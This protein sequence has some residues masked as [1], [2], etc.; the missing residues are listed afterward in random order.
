[1]STSADAPRPATGDAPDDPVLV[2]P[3]GV[4]VLLG[5]AAA[6]VVIAGMKAS[7]DLVG[8][9]FLA[10][11]L[12]VTA[13]PLHQWLNRHLPWRLGTL[14]CLLIVYVLIVVL[15][16]ALVAAM[17]RF[18][19]LLTTYEGQFDDLVNDA[20]ARLDD[21][22]VSAEQIDDAASSL[23]LGGLQGVISSALAGLVGLVSDLAFIVAL[24][25]FMTLDGGEFPKRLTAAASV[26]PQL[27]AAFGTFATGTRT[28]LLVATVFGAI[29]AT[30]DT[31]A[32]ALLGIP[33]PLVW[34]LLA[35]LT[36]YIPNI[37]FVIG[38]IPPAILG[39]LEEGPGLMLAVI[40]VY[41]VLNM[42]IQSGIQPKVVGDAV[43]LS[44][45]L[46]FLSLVF[47]TWVI[48]P[49]G[50]IL[51]I[52]LSLLV[53]AVLVDADPRNSWLTPLVANR[54]GAPE[55]APSHPPRAR[56]R[57]RTS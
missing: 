11:V 43:G 50:A 32:L 3:R 53:R 16:V 8:T 30:A 18:G 10:L 38:L 51:A 28:Y 22:G 15:A 17:A 1:M 36:G 19:S 2:L 37:G 52:P 24:V 29:V 23:Q 7:A 34:G 20:T 26:R 54:D 55:P 9:A 39:L 5:L 35:F 25:F 45:T 49:I 48:G 40:A 27:V 21:L 13:H 46:S 14:A 33:V 41:S 47:W 57:R 56:L 12:T 42:V 31:V 6:V 44:S 4:V